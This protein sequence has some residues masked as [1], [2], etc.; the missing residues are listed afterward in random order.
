MKQVGVFLVDNW[1]LILE[2]ILVLASFILFIFKKKN[3]LIDESLTGLLC[4][5][6]DEAEE[7][8]GSGH[9]K[10]KKDFVMEYALKAK[11]LLHTYKSALSDRIEFLLT[12]PQKK[13]K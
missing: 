11:P 1:R 12:L 10:E 8:F 6:I 5:L 9:G 13:G 2:A 7:K 4:D 3:I